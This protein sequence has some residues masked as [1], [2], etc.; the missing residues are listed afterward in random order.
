MYPPASPIGAGGPWG[1]PP[2]LTP[3]GGDGPSRRPA[4]PRDPRPPEFEAPIGGP[5]IAGTRGCFG[6]V[7][8]AIQRLTAAA[9]A[10]AATASAAALPLHDIGGGAPGR[11]DGGLRPA[12][13]LSGGPIGGCWLGPLGKPPLSVA[14]TG[15]GGGTLSGGAQ[16]FLLATPSSGSAA[17]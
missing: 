7:P 1:P 8:L 15:G 10:S 9:A 11:R 6:T 5:P 16:L 17:P 2:R 3:V 12:A 4:I 14:V 13:A